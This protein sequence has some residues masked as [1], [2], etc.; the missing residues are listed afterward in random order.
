[1]RMAAGSCGGSLDVPAPGKAPHANQ[2]GLE[3]EALSMGAERIGGGGSSWRPPG[4]ALPQKKG[5]AMMP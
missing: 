4:T 5:E 1:M 3:A 2:A